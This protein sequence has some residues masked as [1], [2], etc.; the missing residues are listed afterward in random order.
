MKS[1][2]EIILMTKLAVYDKSHGQKDRLCNAHFRAD[3]IYKKNMW[4]RFYA[5]LGCLIIIAFIIVHEII[6][7]ETD[8]FSL[9]WEVE[10]SRYALNTFFVLIAY[11]LIGSL[12]ANKEYNLR[13]SRLKRYFAALAK[14][15]GS[16]KQ[17]EHL[18]KGDLRHGEPT[19]DETNYS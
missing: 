12:L 15:D 18:Y 6:V 13:Q 19:Y 8:I 11:T 14:L 4:N 9:N 3:Y 10:L 1:K 7:K 16:N 2:K 17:P 5:L